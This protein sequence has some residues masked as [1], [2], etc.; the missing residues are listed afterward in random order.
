MCSFLWRWAASLIRQTCKVILLTA[1]GW[2]PVTVA[3]TSHDSEGAK[4]T[5]GLFLT[6]IMWYSCTWK[7]KSLS[8]LYLTRIY[9]WMNECIRVIWDESQAPL[10]MCYNVSLAYIWCGLAQKQTSMWMNPKAASSVIG[11]QGLNDQMNCLCVE[12]LF[13]HP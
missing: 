12:E 11:C 4:K 1:A 7:W 5:S 2:Q 3:L 13:E 8:N 9:E 6:N 10:L